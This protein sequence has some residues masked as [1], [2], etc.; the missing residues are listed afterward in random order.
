M[1]L[2]F[3]V[4]SGVKSFGNW[5]KIL[6]LQ[7]TTQMIGVGSIVPRCRRNQTKTNGPGGLKRSRV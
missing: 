5:V 3:T 7:I 2:E 1:R 4:K 6:D